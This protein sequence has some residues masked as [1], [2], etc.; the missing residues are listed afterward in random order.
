[1]R[2]KSPVDSRCRAGPAAESCDD[3]AV[4]INARSSASAWEIASRVN[5][6]GRPGKAA[7]RA[8]AAAP[9]RNPGHAVGLAPT[10]FKK[11][12]TFRACRDDRWP[13][14]RSVR[15]RNIW[16]AGAVHI[17]GVTAHPAGIWT[18]QQPGTFSEMM[19]EDGSASPRYCRCWLAMDRWSRCRRLQSRPR[20]ESPARRAGSGRR[21][22]SARRSWRLVSRL[23]RAAGDDG[24]V[25]RGRSVDRQN[26]VFEGREDIVR[27][28]EEICFRRPSGSRAMPYRTSASVMVVVR[29]SRL[30]RSRTHLAT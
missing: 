5:V 10:P 25:F 14:T 22:R 13:R 18:V 1:M 11:K 4:T 19:A 6:T 17:L 8:P 24:V 26:L 28:G 23:A 27:C 2:Q 20:C 15:W 16:R 21:R 9:D 29:S 12:W 7:A 3:L 30:S